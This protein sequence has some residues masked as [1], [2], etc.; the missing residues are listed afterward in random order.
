MQ[1]L[2]RKHIQFKN[3]RQLPF[4]QSFSKFEYFVN[5]RTANRIINN[6]SIRVYVFIYAIAFMI[7][8]IML[9]IRTV[10]YVILEASQ[11]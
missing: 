3:C 4:I 5:Y 10:N 2:I 1:D 6:K 8:R 9:L 7:R 11:L